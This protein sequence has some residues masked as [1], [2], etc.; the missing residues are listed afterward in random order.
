MTLTLEVIRKAIAAALSKDGVLYCTSHLD[1]FEGILFK[2]KDP[3]TF[4]K[5]LSAQ[6]LI[7]SSL[8]EINCNQ[9]IE[10]ILSSVK[11]AVIERSG[12]HL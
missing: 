12:A 1:F 5:S 10:N 8:I 4:L 2:D 6:A 9:I 11:S 3:D 7:V